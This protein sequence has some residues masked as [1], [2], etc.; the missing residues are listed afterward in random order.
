MSTEKTP[1]VNKLILLVLVL[2]LG[3]LIILVVQLSSKPWYPPLKTPEVASHSEE[4]PNLVSEPVRYLPVTNR[5]STAKP[6][7]ARPLRPDVRTV[8]YRP[9]P[10]PRDFFQPRVVPQFD[11]AAYGYSGPPDTPVVSSYGGATS[12]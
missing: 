10:E 6:Q 3:C 1:L 7:P 5:A 2:I 12:A 4:S 8:A 11:N 9:A